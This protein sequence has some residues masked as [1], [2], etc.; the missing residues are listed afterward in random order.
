MRRRSSL[1]VF[2][3]KTDADDQALGFTTAWL[4]ELARHYAR[5]DVITMATGRIALPDNVY[6]RSVGKEKGYGEPR[7]VWEFYRHLGAVLD[8]VDIEACFA[9]MI[10]HF[11]ILARPLL[12]RRRIPIVLWYAHGATPWNLRA[13]L[14]MVDLVATSSPGG[15]R[16][17]SDKV[18]ILGQ[19]IDSD[20]FRPVDGY[21]SPDRFTALF[22]GRI[23]PVKRIDVALETLA[24]L[25]ELQ[26][27]RDPVLRVVGSPI[28]PADRIYLDHLRRVAIEMGIQPHVVFETGHPYHAIHEVYRAA[29]AFIN[30]G[31][32]GSVDKAG[33]E[34]MSSAL[35]IVTSNEAFRDVLG[36]ELARRWVVP[37]RSPGIFAERLEEIA[38]MSAFER[39]SLGERLRG[40][41][42]RD[43]G[44]PR[45]VDRLVGVIDEARR[46]K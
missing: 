21:A 35:P 19:G 26:P 41:V 1:L 7:R 20:R 43:H 31:E 33:L 5:I 22:V 42:I 45:F 12:R 32:T 6:V 8:E 27:C 15:F 13:S 9:H 29:H 16:I 23:G 39:R 11:A 38:E 3:L 28:T 36:P 34:A 4:T 37:R 25:R 18:R 24:R 10:P 17:E 14:P 44:L 46:E 2:N 30:P 40:I